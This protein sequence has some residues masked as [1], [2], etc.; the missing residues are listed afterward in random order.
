MPTFYIFHRKGP[1]TI[2]ALKKFFFFSPDAICWNP[3]TNMI[4][5]IHEII[6]VH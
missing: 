1:E 2:A 6:T 5:A 4:F 3:I